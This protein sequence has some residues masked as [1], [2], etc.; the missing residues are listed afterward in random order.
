MKDVLGGILAGVLGIA[1]WVGSMILSVVV[2]IWIVAQG[3]SLYQSWQE[4]DTQDR[5]DYS[6]EPVVSD[7]QARREFM[8]G[9]DTGEYYLQGAYCGCLFEQFL[10]GRSVNELVN[11]GLMLTED[12]VAAKYDS[13]INYCL[14][15]TY[16]SQSI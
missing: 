2:T 1:F 11:D 15:V 12:Q 13:E 6:S 9:C 3:I 7:S 16:E 14:G 4:P 10:S 8:I 5:Q